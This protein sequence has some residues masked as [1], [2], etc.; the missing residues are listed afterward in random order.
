MKWDKEKPIVRGKC[1]KPCCF[2]KI[3]ASTL[4]VTYYANKKA[5]MTGGVM[6][7]WLQKF[8]ERMK[9]EKGNILPILDNAPSHS[10]IELSNI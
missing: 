9:K 6:D 2:K 4:P 10:H 7:N 8:N 3:E 5:W 1:L